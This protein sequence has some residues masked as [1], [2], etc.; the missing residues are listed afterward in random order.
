MTWL[1]D[2]FWFLIHEIYRL[3]IPCDEP[4]INDISMSKSPVNKVTYKGIDFRIS[5]LPRVSDCN[6]KAIYIMYRVDILYRSDK[7]SEWLKT[8]YDVRRFIVRHGNSPYI[9]WKFLK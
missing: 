6:D 2:K 1:K 7:N 3:V 8:P 9:L 5:R 4:L